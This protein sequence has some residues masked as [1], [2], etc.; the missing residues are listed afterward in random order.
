MGKVLGI[1]MIILGILQGVWIGYKLLV[2][3][4]PEFPNLILPIGLT[5]I[6]VGL[7]KLDK[8]PYLR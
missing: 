6:V 5:I 3:N 4:T 7:I 2:E 8:D 1:F